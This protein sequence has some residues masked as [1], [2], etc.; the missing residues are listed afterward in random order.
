MQDADGISLSLYDVYW[1]VEDMWGRVCVVCLA[2][3]ASIS[4]WG[5]MRGSDSSYVVFWNVENYFDPFDD[6]LTLDDEFTPSGYRHWTWKR[7]LEKRNLMAKTLMSMYDRYGDWPLAVGFAEVENSM[8]LRQ[9]VEHTPLA[10]LRYKIVHHD[11]PDSRGIDVG[12]IYLEEDIDVIDVEVLSVLTGRDRPTRDILHI[13]C[14]MF[15][16]GLHKD[17]VHFFI[18]HWPSK[19]GG[20]EYSRPFRQAAADTLRRAV[21]ALRDSVT[22]LLPW[23]IVTGDFNDTPDSG[24]VSSLLRGTGLVDLAS[25][26][27]RH[28]KGSLKYNGRWELIDHFHVSPVAEGSVMEIYS[29]PMLIEDDDKFLGVKPRRSYY[30]PMWHGGASDHLPVVLVFPFTSGGTGDR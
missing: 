25:G 11:S 29:H 3:S 30:G 2:V 20:D 7:F 16:G 19:F 13:A 12:F 26:L 18:N 10:K 17:T 4:V 28:G 15:T 24:P 1:N 6:S 8:V 9:L 21:V 22:G 14:L 27:Q 5:G 23:V